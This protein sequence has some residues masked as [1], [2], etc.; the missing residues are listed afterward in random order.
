MIGAPGEP[1]G[2]DGGAGQV[3]LLV[4]DVSH[5][6]VAFGPYA[7]PSGAS[8]GGAF[9]SA[10]AVGRVNADGFDDLAVGAPGTTVSAHAGRGPR[11]L[12]HG[13]DDA[14]D[15]RRA[16]RDDARPCG[17]R[18]TTRTSARRSPIADF[19]GDGL[20]DVVVGVPGQ[21]VD[22]GGEVRIYRGFPTWTLLR[23]LTTSTPGVQVEFGSSVAAPTST[24]T[25][26]STCSSARRTA[27]SNTTIEAGYVVPFLEHESGR[28]HAD[29]RAA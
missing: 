2:A 14:R 18:P 15:L 5:T 4:N 13:F 12:P 10:L 24:T 25:A 28:G 17:R 22:A 21:I 29:G 16:R 19:D 20:G 11:R 7:D 9:G 6:G 23:S 3:Y 26:T 1:V 8:T 27:T